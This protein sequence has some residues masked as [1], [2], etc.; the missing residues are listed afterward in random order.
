MY[1]AAA[2]EAAAEAARKSC[3]AGPSEGWGFKWQVQ[4]ST[5][6]HPE[7]VFHVRDAGRVEAQRLW[8][9]AD[10]RWN[11]AF[12]SVTRD[13]S[14]LNGWLKADA[15]LNMPR[16]LVTRDVSKLSGPVWRASWSRGPHLSGYPCSLPLTPVAH[17]TPPTSAATASAATASQSLNSLRR[18]RTR[19]LAL[20][21]NQAALTARP[22]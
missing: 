15:E 4:R 21:P 20:G 9:K 7:H 1:R 10:A 19:T 2:A 3:G 22:E 17:A 13:V 16:M 5:S 14:R 11:M 8:L 18:T 6:A 12:M